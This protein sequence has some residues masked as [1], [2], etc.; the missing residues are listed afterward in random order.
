[1]FVFLNFLCRRLGGGTDIDMKDSPSSEKR[2]NIGK[3]KNVF[4]TALFFIVNPRFLLCFGIAWIITN[5]WSY[6]ALGVGTYY[7]I[8]WLV[9]IATAY[10]TFLWFP[11]TPE[12][13]FTVIIAI[14]L[15]RLLFPRDERT[16]GILL[17]ILENVKKEAMEARERRRSKRKNRKE[18]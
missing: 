3:I 9:A 18:K 10:L 15:L 4:K 5:G 7:G 6:V 17:A 2:K 1:M 14:G 8:A 13:I 11:F 16:L 12:K